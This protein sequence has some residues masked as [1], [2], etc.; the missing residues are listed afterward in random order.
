MEYLEKIP[1]LPQMDDEVKNKLSVVPSKAE[2]VEYFTTLIFNAAEAAKEIYRS[3]LLK[4]LSEYAVPQYSPMQIG[5]PPVPLKKDLLYLLAVSGGGQG[6]VG[7]EENQDLHLQRGVAKIVTQ[8]EEREEEAGMFVCEESSHTQIC[9]NI[10]END[11]TITC[12]S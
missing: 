4:K 12:L 2:D 10:I 9:L 5:N 7:S 1:Y 11:G 6:L 8:M 3:P